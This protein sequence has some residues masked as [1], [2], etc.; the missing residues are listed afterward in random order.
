MIK[1]FDY[2]VGPLR[3]AVQN[4]IAIYWEDPADLNFPYPINAGETR[5]FRLDEGAV[6]SLVNE[7]GKLS[8]LGHALFGWPRIRL[9]VT[10]MADAKFS[11]SL[12]RVVPGTD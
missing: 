3:R 4:R 8:R 10:T 2:R 11:V 5:K 9:C 1:A 7:S 6:R 12:E